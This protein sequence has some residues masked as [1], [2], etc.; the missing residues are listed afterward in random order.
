L[1]TEA[2]EERALADQKASVLF[3]A[4]GTATGVAV[5]VM[6][7]KEWSP[8]ELSVLPAVLWWLGTATVVACVVLLGAAVYPRLGARPA[9][10]GATVASFRE[11]AS[12]DDAHVLRLALEASSRAELGG[13]SA[14]LLALGRLTTSKYHCIRLA[15]WLLVVAVVLQ[16]AVLLIA[17]QRRA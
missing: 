10:N 17:V 7:S 1:L 6:V 5:A 8:A 2:R 12:C 3:A 16:S 14:Q 9:R 15:L 11:I 4:V 13:L